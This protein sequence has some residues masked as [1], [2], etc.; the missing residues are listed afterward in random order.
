MFIWS[1]TD[2]RSYIQLIFLW[3]PITFIRWLTLVPHQATIVMVGTNVSVCDQM[4]IYVRVYQTYTFHKHHAKNLDSYK[5]Y[6]WLWS[7]MN[8]TRQLELTS[9]RMKGWSTQIC[10]QPII[11]VFS[12]R[13]HSPIPLKKFLLEKFPAWRTFNDKWQLYSITN[14]SDHSYIFQT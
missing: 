7:W 6:L 11:V 12:R 13:Y 9:G 2:K 1:Q 8:D 4:N 10:L 5:I 14:I 3:M